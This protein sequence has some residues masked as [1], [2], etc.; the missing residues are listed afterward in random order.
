[1]GIMKASVH[2]AGNKARSDDAR[3]RLR[4]GPARTR[5]AAVVNAVVEMR[6]AV[7]K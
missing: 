6:D 7:K 3:R 5:N 4:R 1:M 2:G